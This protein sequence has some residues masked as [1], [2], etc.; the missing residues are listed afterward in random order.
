MTREE[1]ITELN[2][3][4][5]DYWDDDGYG[6]ETK[7]Y[8][9]TMLALDMA[10]EA[11]SAEPCE[12]CRTCNK[13]SECECGEKG[14]KNGTS[15]GYSIGECKDYK[16]CEDTISRREVLRI[17]SHATLSVNDVVSMIEKLPSVTPKQK[18]GRWIEHKHNGSSHLECSECSVWFARIHLV[19]NSYCPNCG[20]KMEREGTE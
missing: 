4:K 13:W 11:L 20:T 5:E 8:G 16:P 19:R 15:I 14:H 3:L 18:M 10:I 6:H 2:I 12:D 7:Q 17:A 1:A 9:D